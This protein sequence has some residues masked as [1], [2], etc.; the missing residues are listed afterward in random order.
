MKMLPVLDCRARG[1][2]NVPRGG[3][4]RAGEIDWYETRSR[5]RTKQK[6]KED[7]WYK[8]KQIRIKTGGIKTKQAKQGYKVYETELDE[9]QSKVFFC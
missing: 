7:K 5:L 8:N 9:K 1:E 3:G 4:D 2:G 6:R